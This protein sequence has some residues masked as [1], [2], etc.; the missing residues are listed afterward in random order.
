MGNDRRLRL[1][2]YRW[3]QTV[4]TAGVG[5]LQCLIERLCLAHPTAVFFQGSGGIFLLSSSFPIPS[6]PAALGFSASGGFFACLP[7]L[8]G[9]SPLILGYSLYFWLSCGCPPPP[10][11]CVVLGMSLSN[12]LQTPLRGMI[13]GENLLK[14]GLSPIKMGVPFKAS[15]CASVS[16][17]Q[18]RQEGTRQLEH[19]PLPG[20]SVP[21]DLPVPS[22]CLR[23]LGRSQKA[24]GGVEGVVVGSGGRKIPKWEK[25]PPNSWFWWH[26]CWPQLATS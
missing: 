1:R 26:R 12:P 7:F 6:S 2:G 4:G 17:L 8:G 11:A 14:Q 23:Y 10:M 13:W 21:S 9:G 16:L 19:L 24:C 3:L 15:A 20:A 22:I 5:I 18:Q 25:R